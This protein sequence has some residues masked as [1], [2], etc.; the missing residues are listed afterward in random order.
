MER[1]DRGSD[2]M[3]R[4]VTDEDLLALVE[5]TLADERVDAVREALRSDRELLVRV[6]GM[7]RD[8]GLL[9][10]LAERRI[11]APDDLIESAIAGA[12]REA[13]TGAGP[14]RAPRFTWRSVAAA[15]AIGVAFLGVWAG[16][17][18][19]LLEEGGPAVQPG[20][21]VV[22]LADA[23][24]PSLESPAPAPGIALEEPAPTPVAPAEAPPAPDL[25][26]PTSDEALRQFLANMDAADPEPDEA[27]PDEPVDLGRAVGLLREGR[28]AIRLDDGWPS[29]R[30]FAAASPPR[31]GVGV[32]AEAPGRL[33]VEVDAG[34]GDEALRAALARAIDRLAATTQSGVTLVALP[35]PGGGAGS[36]FSLDAEDVVW[37]EGPR[38]SWGGAR[39]RYEAPISSA[40]R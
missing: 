26:M 40:P 25:G 29:P 12:E 28:L 1:R 39:T 18:W 2:P 11:P 6:Q 24:P 20:G 32:P 7:A 19:L 37:W 21:E 13:L 14:R 22:G 27:A 8:R 35:V 4:R 36:A 3:A 16:V 30:A 17:M 15:A 5:G 9:K 33:T 38:R 31:V 10:Q 34:A 23:A